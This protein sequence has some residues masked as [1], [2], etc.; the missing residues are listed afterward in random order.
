M[1]VRRA[2]IPAAGDLHSY[3]HPPRPPIPNQPTAPEG[4]GVLG[5]R[6]PNLSSEDEKTANR[7]HAACTA[8]T[9]CCASPHA[10][11]HHTPC[12]TP[13]PILHTTPRPTCHA[14]CAIPHR[15]GTHSVV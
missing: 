13:C 8:L 7:Y 14:P 11:P 15:M 9:A 12:L 2:C 10:A 6:M 5:P 3:T 1:R 4:V